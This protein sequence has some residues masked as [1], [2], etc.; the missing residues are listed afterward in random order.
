MRVKAA[1][2]TNAFG[3]SQDVM[4][5]ALP[6][7]AQMGYGGLEF[8]EQYLAQANLAWLRDIMAAH[9][10]EIVQ[11][12][13]YFDFTAGQAKWDESL[14]TAERYIDYALQLGRPMIRTYTGNVGSAEAT[15]AQWEACVRGLQCCCRMGKP[16]G[17]VFALETHQVI[18]TGPNLTDT[19]ASTLRLLA[20][21]GQENLK[22]NLQTPLVD[23]PVAYSAEKLGEHVVHVHAHNWVGG[24]PAAGGRFTF[25][26]SGDE[27]FGEFVRVLRSRGFDGYISVEH[28]THHPP[29]ETA[30]HEIEYLKRLLSASL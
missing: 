16:H 25:L 3:N 15:P 7:L 13:P 17:I 20:D 18:H 2:C 26:D 23:E 24:W 21:T 27:D 14:K 8:W 6:R 29:Y 1:F 19:S 28:G 5:E 11:I 12:C 22:V 30:L 4:A 9:R 10:M